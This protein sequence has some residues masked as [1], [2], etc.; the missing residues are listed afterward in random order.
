MND[1]DYE[2][3]IVEPDFGDMRH[4]FRAATI[5]AFRKDAD[6]QIIGIYFV[7]DSSGKEIYE[8]VTPELMRAL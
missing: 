1:S 4:P 2:I 5:F 8:E 7:E 6:E 3:E